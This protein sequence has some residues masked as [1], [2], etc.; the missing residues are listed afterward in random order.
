MDDFNTLYNRLQSRCPAVGP[1]LAQQLISDSWHVLQSRREWS[2]RRRNAIFA[3]PNIYIT[4]TVSTNVS[5]GQ[6]T[7]ITGIGTAWTAQMIGQQIRVGGLT[8]PYYTINT[9][10]SATALTID[11]PWA[12]AEAVSQPYQILQ[13][14]YPVPQDFNYFVVALSPKDG[15]KLWTNLTQVELALIDPQ[16]TDTGQTYAVAFRDYTATYNGTIGPVMPCGALGSPPISTTTNGYSYVAPATYIVRVVAGGVTGTA[17]WQWMRGGMLDWAPTIPTNDSAQD[18][19]DGVQIYWPVSNGP[20]TAGD[21]FIINAVPG[22]TQGTPR[23]E[24]WP[25]PTYN[26]YVYPYIY[27]A[28]E[29]DISAAAPSL[30]PF[31]ANRGEVLLEL[32]LAACARFPG[33]DDE[34]P[35][36]YYSLPLAKTHEDRAERLIWD[37]ER[38]DE[39]VGLT[40]V[41]Y[42]TWPF[43]G[44]FQD[45]GW[46]QRHAPYLYG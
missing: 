44:P 5:T 3:P 8:N 19:M 13:V 6:P 34:H 21:L 11:L 22:V 32:A 18:L 23:Y 33:T 39:E 40:N 16:R 2:W 7:L 1:I 20:Y 45:G 42:E 26:G 37:M 28:K 10:L 36:I 14:Y 17:T 4:G 9:V 43:G 25:A 30:P 29:S 38:N 15:Y 46:Q 24:L 35:N 27:I 12:G 31:V 41:T